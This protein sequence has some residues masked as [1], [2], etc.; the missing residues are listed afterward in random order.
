MADRLNNLR[1]FI[2][3]V[4]YFCKLRSLWYPV[5]T[6]LAAGLVLL[7]LLL[8]GTGSCDIAD[9]ATY[10][11]DARYAQQGVEVTISYGTMGPRYP[12]AFL[13]LEGDSAS[14]GPAFLL[15]GQQL[16]ISSSSR[17]SSESRKVLKAFLLSDELS[18]TLDAA[19]I[20][21]ETLTASNQQGTYILNWTRPATQ[22]DAAYTVVMLT[23]SG[24]ADPDGSWH[25]W[26]DSSLIAK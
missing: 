16:A 7:G 5:K 10:I 2:L 24:Y 19:G 15:S 11:S 21:T 23:G 12:E 26:G 8:L 25:L 22:S 4:L 18:K 14:R 17:S 1:R 9:S 20:T 3:C 6:D 13:I